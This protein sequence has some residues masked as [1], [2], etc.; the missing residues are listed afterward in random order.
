[1]CVA[2]KKTTYPNFHFEID[3]K[4]YFYGIDEIRANYKIVLRC[5]KILSGSKLPC[6]YTSTV[7]PS[8]FLKEIIQKR[9]SEVNNSYSKV[10]DNSDPRVYHIDNDDLK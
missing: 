5:Q 8:D 7:L 4:S 6:I 10:L 9:P 2:P 3:G 1:M